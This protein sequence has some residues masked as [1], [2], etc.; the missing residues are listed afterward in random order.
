MFCCIEQTVFQAFPQYVSLW[1]QRVNLLNMLLYNYF[2]FVWG[3]GLPSRFRVGQCSMASFT[4]VTLCCD[5]SDL[6]SQVNPAVLVSV[7]CWHSDAE[8]IINEVSIKRFMNKRTVLYSQ[9]SPICIFLLIQGFTIVK[10]NCFLYDNSAL[11]KTHVL[12]NCSQ[13]I[14]QQLCSVAR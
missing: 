14:G 5:R 7:K 2:V 11:Y 3:S 10:Q 1:C 13:L 8:I 12:W 6:M 4:I 9:L